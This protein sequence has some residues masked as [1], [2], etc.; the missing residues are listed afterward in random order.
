MVPCWRTM[1]LQHCKWVV[2]VSQLILFQKAAQRKYLFSVSH[3]S[4]PI[5]PLSKFQAFLPNLSQE[6]RHS[7]WSAWKDQRAGWTRS[8][9]GLIYVHWHFRVLSSLCVSS[10]Q[11]RSRNTIPK[12]LFV[13]FTAYG[14]DCRL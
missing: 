1:A 4:S 7:P 14:M 8:M 2:F 12:F 10:H 13:C 11:E 6:K 9:A 3:H 5:T